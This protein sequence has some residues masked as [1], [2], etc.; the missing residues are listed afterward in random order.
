MFDNPH[1]LERETV[2]SEFVPSCSSCYQYRLH[3]ASQRLAQTRPFIFLKYN[4][5]WP[6]PGSQNPYHP[7]CLA[8]HLIGS[9]RS[10][11]ASAT[12]PTHQNGLGLI[13]KQESIY[14]PFLLVSLGHVSSGLRSSIKIIRPTQVLHQSFDLILML[15]FTYPED[16][17]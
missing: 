1:R 5:H 11:S 7:K 6:Q 14:Y 4:H 9:S 12:H 2:I 3:W 13:S 10:S 15:Q 16:K 17:I 8:P